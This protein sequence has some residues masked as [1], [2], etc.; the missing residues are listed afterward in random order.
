VVGKDKLITEVEIILETLDLPL[1]TSVGI[2]KP[3]VAEFPPNIQNSKYSGFS[4]RFS[5]IGLPLKFG[6]L[7]N[8]IDNEQNII[9]MATIEIEV[10]EEIKHYDREISNYLQ[11]ILLSALARSGTTWLMRLLISHPAIVGYPHYPH[12]LH[13]AGYAWHACRVLTAPS[14]FTGLSH[15]DLFQFDLQRI[16]SNSFFSL[17]SMI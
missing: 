17:R 7:I 10:E 16:S 2:S 8:A 4:C 11:P 12:E 9:P 3:D 14:G 5:T 6:I 13:I 1:Q 15:P